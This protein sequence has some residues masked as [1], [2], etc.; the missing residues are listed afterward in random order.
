MAR[1]DSQESARFGMILFDQWGRRYYAELE[2]ET[3][4]PTGPIQPLF[5]APIMVDTKYVRPYG[6][7][8]PNRVHV[9]VDGLERDLAEKEDQRERRAQKMILKHFPGWKAKYPPPAV[10]EAIY[11]DGPRPMPVELCWAM[12][13]GNRWVLGL[14]EH[15]PPWSEQEPFKSYFNPPE[16]KRKERE[17]AMEFPDVEGIEDLAL[18]PVVAI[19]D[20]NI[21]PRSPRTNE[22]GL[23]DLGEGA[24][25]VH[26][27]WGT[28]ERNRTVQ[29]VEDYLRR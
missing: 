21:D 10:E 29:Q 4:Y 15:R 14:T 2:K 25:G 8:A 5:Q 19:T 9:D 11:G 24:G 20:E 26:A 1:Y 16:K 27:S 6:R 13:Q 3:L 12:K 18:P 23:P 7:S 22:Q 28:Q 17:Q